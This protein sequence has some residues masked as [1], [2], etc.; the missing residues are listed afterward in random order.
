MARPLMLGRPFAGVPYEVGL[1]AVGRVHRHVGSDTTMADFALRRTPISDAVT[2]AI[3]G[4][5]NP[6]QARSNA[7]AASFPPLT[8]DQMI[9]VR[10]IYEQD[11]KPI[12]HQ[13]W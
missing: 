5:R 10:A 9:D 12:V 1:A 13:R 6:D 2:V 4:A 7:V 11:L 8:S 3:L